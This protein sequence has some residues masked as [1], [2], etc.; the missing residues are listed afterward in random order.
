MNTG[1]FCTYGIMTSVK[2]IGTKQLSCA[3][4]ISDI[5]A[6]NKD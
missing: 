5:D 4:T 6:N 2:F 3:I 1:E